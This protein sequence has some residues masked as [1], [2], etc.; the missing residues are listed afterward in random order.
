MQSSR[1]QMLADG[2][3]SIADEDSKLIIAYVHNGIIGDDTVAWYLEQGYT[4]ERVH[5]LTEAEYAANASS[6]GAGVYSHRNGENSEPTISG[7]YWFDG[8]GTW[9]QTPPET[10]R[11][12]PV[13]VEREEE[14]GAIIW[15]GADD[16]ANY[17]CADGWLKG[18]WYGP[19]I[20]PW[21]AP[22]LPQSSTQEVD[23]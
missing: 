7:W 2:Y 22:V 8:V 17:A 5:V 3:Y 21:H 11:K 6:A 13:F 9:R 10:I 23:E 14:G 20:S 18:Q 19:I 16:D 15:Y 1:T 12:R 4:F